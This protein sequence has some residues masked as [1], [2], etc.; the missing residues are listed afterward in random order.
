MWTTFQETSS[1]GFQFLIEEETS[2]D[3]SR[4]GIIFVDHFS[5][6]K[7]PI[8]RNRSSNIQLCLLWK[9]SHIFPHHS[10]PSLNCILFKHTVSMADDQDNDSQ[11]VGKPQ[12]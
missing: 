5:S 9:P 1:Y 3:V 12:V 2:V 7:L 11:R 6:L 8:L 4:L 10:Y